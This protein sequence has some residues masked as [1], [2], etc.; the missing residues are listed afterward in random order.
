MNKEKDNREAVRK[1]FPLRARFEYWFDNRMARGSLGL[2]RALIIASLVFAILM[3][4]LIILLGFSE[5]GEGASVV[6]NGIAT[7][8]NAWMP[9]FEDGSPGYL[10]FMTLIAVAGVLFTSVLIGIVT[11]A[12]EEKI[13]D[14]KR[15]N[16][17]V[18]ESGHIVVLGFYPGEYTLIEQL[19]LAAAGDP[20]CIVVAEDMERQEMEQEIKNNVDV[21]KNFRIVCRTVDITDPASIE[22]CSVETCKTVI[23]S[24]TEDSRT[25]KAVL[26]VSALLQEKNAEGIRINAI[27][28]KNEYRFPPSLAEAHNIA[29]L[30]TN[31][32][33]AKMIAHSCTQTGLSDTFRETFNFE[34][35]EFYLIDLPGLTGCSF[36]ELTL[37]LNHGVPAGVLREDRVKLNPPADF[38]LEEGDRFLVFAEENDTAVLEDLPDVG[39]PEDPGEDGTLE[40]EI[41]ETV[42]FGYNET[43]PVVL[44]DLP[45]NV[46]R[47]YMAGQK[48]NRDEKKELERIASER[49]IELEYCV[50]NPRSEK[51]LLSM[52]QK[53]EHIV[54]LN[55]HGKDDEAAD[56]D[57]IFLILN[58]RDLRDRYG[59]KFNITIEM[60]KEHNQNLVGR[61]DHTD[62]LV[63]SSMSSLFLAQLAESPELIGV[64]RE[65][66]SNTGNE[67][68]LKNAEDARLTGPRTVRELRRILLRRGYIFLGYLNAEKE[69]RFNIPLEE[70]LDPGPE[71]CFI[72]LG[73]K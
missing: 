36:E 1:K 43:L 18:L 16:S 50:C 3:S 67:L 14:L 47:V 59:L 31:D 2:I 12:I 24:P 28:S 8:I 65:I 44:R 71:E 23:I 37:R 42:I 49:D 27:I 64:F 30:Q 15:G 13:S 19:I 66:L 22:K 17:L 6:W 45:E 63:S 11:S 25:I 32:I 41:T 34:G 26:A 54:I 5:E 72:V 10:A 68:Y 46:S 58:L 62:F 21:P 9:S 35:S 70:T 51:D 53:T 55:D 61:G 29:T 7:V 57:N 56:M 60:R 39:L 4:G 38:L 73:E 40:E 20:F 69:S 48:M 33:L 52:A